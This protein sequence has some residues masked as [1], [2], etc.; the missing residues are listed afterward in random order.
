M[1]MVKILDK[2]MKMNL[3]FLKY[4]SLIFIFSA[5]YAAAQNKL[6]IDKEMKLA[7]E[8]VAGTLIPG[9]SVAVANSDGLLWSGVSGYSNIEDNQLVSQSHTFGIGNITNKFIELLILQMAEENILDLNSTPQSILGEK[10]SHIENADSATLFQLLNHTSGIYSWANDNDWQRRGRGIQMNPKYIWHKE[11]P[12]KYIAADQHPATHTP[13][14]A[15]A[16][17]NSNYTLLGL[18]LEKISGVLLEDQVRSRILEPLNLHSTYYHGF[19]LIPLGR[20]VGSYH[21][22]TDHFISTVGINAKFAFGQDQLMDT[23][24]ASLS[25]EGLAGGIVST[26]RD[27]ALFAMAIKNGK[28]LNKVSAEMLT[29][30]HSDI[31]G[32]TSDLLWLD[33]NEI[34]IVSFANLG[35]VGGSNSATAE[36]LNNYVERILLPIA[37]KYA[38]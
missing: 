14:T 22:A 10:V 8:K 13:G 19:E 18:I 26:P 1:P 37:Q 31:L 27:I 25:A 28:L 24:G 30:I 32:F 5:P 16:Y 21:L 2:A 38:K 20:H 36:Y 35:T 17:S 11:E 23:S 15:Y 9:L 33:R 34:V 7:I 6:Q 29:N 12:L 3:T 4:I